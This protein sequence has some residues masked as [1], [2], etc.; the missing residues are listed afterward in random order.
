MT[1]DTNSPTDRISH[2]FQLR[3]HRLLLISGD[4]SCSL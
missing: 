3:D 2:P 1:Y 4:C